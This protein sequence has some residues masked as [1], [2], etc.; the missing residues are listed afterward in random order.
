MR[1][2]ENVY[3]KTKKS[4]KTSPQSPARHRLVAIAPIIIDAEN[5]HAA[6]DDGDDDDHDEND[7]YNQLPSSSIANG[8]WTVCVCV[9]FR[10]A[11]MLYRCFVDN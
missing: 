3:N 10:D 11:S 8:R 1:V 2:G 9:C 5:D 7:Q 4:K 6:D